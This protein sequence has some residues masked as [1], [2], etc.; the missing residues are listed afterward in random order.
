MKQEEE[1]E[2]WDDYIGTQCAELGRKTCEARDAGNFSLAD[3]LDR[4]WKGWILL[5]RLGIE[6][7]QKTGLGKKALLHVY[8]ERQALEEKIAEILKKKEEEK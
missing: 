7:A 8:N 2:D 1:C 6:Q 3:K 4:E 5:R